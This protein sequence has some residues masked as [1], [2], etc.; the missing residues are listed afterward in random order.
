MDVFSVCFQSKK[1]A[2]SG[3]EG[4]PAHEGADAATPLL[5]G[6]VLQREVPHLVATPCGQSQASVR[7]KQPAQ[8]GDPYVPPL[9]TVEPTRDEQLPAMGRCSNMWTSITALQGHAQLVG[10]G[11]NA[12]PGL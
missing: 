11:R 1:K 3:N 10:D 7:P 8:A 6:I 9:W 5:C 4:V 2:R 12:A